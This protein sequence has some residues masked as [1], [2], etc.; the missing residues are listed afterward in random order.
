MNLKSMK[1]TKTEKEKSKGAPET[2]FSDYPWGLEMS[3]EN[4]IMK[5]LGMKASAFKIGETVMIA[6]KAKVI[7]ISSNVNIGSSES[8][9]IRIQITD[10]AIGKPKSG[11]FEQWQAIKK[12]GPE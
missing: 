4:E 8:N 6:A 10:M 7:G 2:A 1:L 11:K 5:K 9:N 12:K 3:L